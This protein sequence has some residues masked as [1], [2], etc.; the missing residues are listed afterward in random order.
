V[1]GNFHYEPTYFT[2]CRSLDQ[3]QQLRDGRG[4]SRKCKHNNDDEERWTVRIAMKALAAI[5]RPRKDVLNNLHIET[6]GDHL[7]LLDHH[8]L[9]SMKITPSTAGGRRRVIMDGLL[10]R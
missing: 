10:I 6:M 5:V 8:L 2:K 9:R 7:A 4:K 1:F 3:Q